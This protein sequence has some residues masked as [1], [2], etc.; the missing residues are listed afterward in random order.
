M[1]LSMV[2][3]DLTLPGGGNAD[4]PDIDIEDDGSYAWIVFRAGHRRRV[5]HARAAARRL[6]VRGARVHRRGRPVERAE[7]RHERRRPRLRGRADARRRADLR[8]LARPRPLPARLPARQHRRRPPTPSPR[9][10]PTDQNDSAIA[11]R[12]TGADG[13]SVARARYHDGEDANGAFG[14]EFTVSRG[15]LGP[16][17]DPGVFIAADR[18]GDVAVA[19]VQGTPGARDAGGRDLR[20]PAGRAVHRRRPRPTSARPAPS[21]AGGRATTRGA[22]RRSAS[23][24]TASLIGQTTNTRWCRRRR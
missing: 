12:L 2:P 19:M 24:W 11:W 21:C 22:R 10:P 13:N 8:L 17:A 20:P 6:A 16:I 5:A 9:S 14:G 15:D 18:S 4:S 23:T 3:Q 7:G 1:T